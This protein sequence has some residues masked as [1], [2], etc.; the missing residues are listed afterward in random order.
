MSK[1]YAQSK[2]KETLCV[3][4]KL[5][6]KEA[7]TALNVAHHHRKKYRKEVRTYFCGQCQAWHLT[8]LGKSLSL[9]V[10]EKRNCNHTKTKIQ[11]KTTPNSRL[12]TETCLNCNSSRTFSRDKG[13]GRVNYTKWR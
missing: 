12:Y 9:S 3:K 7:R 5:T 2:K 13:R 11:S 4:N 6:K 1:F 8:S 10:E